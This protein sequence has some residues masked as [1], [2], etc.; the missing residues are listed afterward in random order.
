VPGASLFAARSTDRRVRTEDIVRTRSTIRRMAF[1]CAGA[2]AIVPLAAGAAAAQ[3]AEELC[4]QAPGDP[5]TEALC[6]AFADDNGDEGENGD[7]E[8][9]LDALDPEE[10]CALQEEAP[11]EFAPLL[12]AL[13]PLIDAICEAE[14]EE[15]EP[16][17]P[18]EEEDESEELPE[19]E[20][21]EDTTDA[22]P[23][24]ELPRTGGLAGLAGLG[25]LGAGA[26]LRRLGSGG[27]VS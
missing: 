5:I 9:P 20:E 18:E 19:T 22:D 15:Q 1:V 26:A 21:P 16:E 8:G 7:D 25:L 13:A 6:D 24:G 11:E 3:S 27:S 23:S 2:L 14:E 10:L 4:E 12:D 17:A